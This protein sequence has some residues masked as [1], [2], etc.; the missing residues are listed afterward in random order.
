M[1]KKRLSLFSALTISLTFAF[2]Q[3]YWQ[4]EV[5]Y[6]IQVTL[7]D[8]AH[9][10]HGHVAFEYINHSPDALD[11]IYV[12]LW[13]NAYDNGNTALAKQLYQDGN[14]IMKYITEENRGYIDSLHFKG[15]EIDLKWEF[16]PEHIDIAKVHLS[17]PLKSGQR[18][19]IQT[20]FRVKIPSGKISRLGHVGESYQITQWYPKPAVYDKNGWHQMPYLTQGEFYSEYGSFDVEITLPKNYVVGATGDLQTATEIQFLDSLAEEGQQLIDGLGPQKG[21]K[22]GGVTPFPASSSE[23]K[24]LRYLQSNVHDFAWFADKRYAV[25]KGQVA[26]PHSKKLVTSCAM[27][28]PS[29]AAVWKNSIEYINDGTYYYSLWNGDYPYNHVTAVDGTISAGGGMEYPNV[30]VIGN[31][32][33]ELELEIVIVHEVGHNW[34]YGILGSNERDHGWMDE[35]LNTL[36]EVR[37]IMT[38][39]PENTYLADMLGGGGFNFHGL[40]YH[41]FNDVTYRTVAALGVDQPIQ[42]HSA[43]FRSINYGVIMYQKTGLVFDYLKYYLGED[44]FDD[45]MRS[46]YD[47]WKFKH[48]QP[49]D[50]RKSLEKSTGEDLG[51]LFEQL[52]EKTNH[53]DFKI[54]RVRQKNGKTE[55]VLKNVGNVDGPMPVSA[56]NADEVVVTQWTKPGVKKEKLIFD[57]TYTAFR[58]D[59]MQQIPEVNRQN[60]NWNKEQLLNKIEPLNYRMFVGYNRADENNHFVLPLVGANAYDKFMIG[61]LFH[62]FALAPNN[63]RYFVAPMYS[64]GRNMVS[65][66]GELSYYKFSKNDRLKYTQYGLSVKSFKDEDSFD[67][68]QSFFA[69]ASPYVTWLLTNEQKRNPWEHRITLLSLNKRTA[70]GTTMVD[71]L[72]GYLSYRTNFKNRDNVLVAQIRNDYVENMTNGDQM[73]RI[74]AD[75]TYQYRYKKQGKSRWM[76]VRGFVGGNYLFETS[77]GG[78]AY[79][80]GMA[81]GGMNGFQDVFVEEYFLNRTA[82]SGLFQNQRVENMGGFRTTSDETLMSIGWM[83]STNVFVELPFAFKGLGVFTDAGMIVANGARTG[84]ANTG[85]GFRISDVFGVYFPLW[86]TENIAGS[87][88]FDNYGDKIRFSLHLNIVNSGKIRDVLMR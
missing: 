78:N 71:E 57:Q 21:F 39:Y 12:H 65:G 22:R 50:I 27:F 8:Q 46:Y 59:P 37:Y 73:G 60:N 54:Q 75:G 62:N 17:K 80:Y 49:D 14:D 29:N 9:F 88:L 18:V 33:S 24:T 43:E 55:V 6:N 74:T 70:R 56:M 41:D 36:N 86:A 5:N 3:D 7:D 19:T 34:F 30:T 44:R 32:S 52:I 2:S 66:I 15:D 64:V 53:V 76:E 38:K 68:N 11:F 35:G 4:Q 84:F 31:A 83:A 63:F 51:W 79:R 10:L 45:A 25:L 23:T 72:G 87:N 69:V 47:E 13:P 48:P 82:T 42:T 28:V 85:L 81:L 58:I 61:G 40:C 26:L 20:P 16:D 67:G 1:M 77:T